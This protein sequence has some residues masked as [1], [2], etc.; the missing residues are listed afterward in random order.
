MTVR[1]SIVSAVL[2][3]GSLAIGHAL[4]T[5]S[6]PAREPLAGW[7]LRIG[8]WSGQPATRLSERELAV[9]GVDEYLNRVYYNEHGSPV[10]LYVGY[11]ES[12]RQGDTIHSPLNCLPGAGWTSVSAGRIRLPVSRRGVPGAEA[13]EPW[14]EVNRHIVEKG[15]DQQFVLYWYQSHGRVVASEYWAK[16]YLVLD[17]IRTNRSDG[18]LIRVM[19]P[20]IDPRERTERDVVDFVRAIFPLLDRYL[21]S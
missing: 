11:Y 8:G 19:S 21:P 13:S 5:E 2:V 10:G 4:K 16:L 17:A 3:A 12:Q 6:A 20:V 9:L 15:A 7:P 18:A 1:L 14:I